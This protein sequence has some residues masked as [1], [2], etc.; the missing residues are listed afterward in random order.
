MAHALLSPRGMVHLTSPSS[1]SCNNSLIGT[2]CRIN[3]PASTLR[4]PHRARCVSVSASRDSGSSFLPG[5]LVGGAIFGALGYYFA[6]QI[7][8]ALLSED[9]RLRL[10]RFLEE[11]KKSPKAT[12]QDLA[13]K[14]EQLNAAIDEVS[15]KIGQE[16][17]A[18]ETAGAS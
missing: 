14:I 12:K 4:R 5:F 8:K 7:S 1:S 2:P 18:E 6:P 15:S 11:E 13:E 10:P 16:Q 17:P 9:Q 3:P